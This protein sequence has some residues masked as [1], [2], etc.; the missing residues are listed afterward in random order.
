[1]SN[2]DRAG[3]SGDATAFHSALL[4][5]SMDVAG[6]RTLDEL[7]SALATHLK[8]VVPFDHLG[9][10]LIDQH[11]GAFR[12]AVIEPSNVGPVP[13]TTG[14]IRIPAVRMPGGFK[15]SGAG[16]DP[17]AAATVAANAAVSA[18]LK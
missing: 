16:T 7:C 15:P 18:A 14:T 11:T 2:A 8:H 1:M 9:L 3:D 13:P 10:I 4:R 12:I 6:Y 5:L 17:A